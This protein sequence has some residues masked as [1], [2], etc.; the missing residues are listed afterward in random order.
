MST[1]LPM[2]YLASTEKPRGASRDNTRG[3]PTCLSL[4]EGGATP[5][6]FREVAQEPDVHESICQ[7]GFTIL[8]STER[9]HVSPLYQY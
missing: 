5:A 4:I 3:L 6:G 1:Q 2:V 9:W 7:S 8:E